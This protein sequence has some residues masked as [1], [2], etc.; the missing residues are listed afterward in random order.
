[1]LIN[2]FHVALLG[3]LFIYTLRGS[4]HAVTRRLSLIPL[5]MCGME[6]FLAEVLD[7]L[8]FPVLGILL[9]LARVAVAVCCV[10]AVRR[11]AALARARSEKRVRTARARL[12]AL[13][14]RSLQK[15]AA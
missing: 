10:L 11:D 12:Y 9:A 14:S 4:R 3:V 7:T 15:T 8:A 2:L 6:I 5:T 1:M 13:E